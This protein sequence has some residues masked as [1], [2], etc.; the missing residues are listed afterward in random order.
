MITSETKNKYIQIIN[1]IGYEDPAVEAIVEFIRTY[2]GTED[3]AFAFLCLS[4]TGLLMQ[5]K[6]LKI[7]A[8]GYDQ[9]EESSDRICGQIESIKRDFG[10]ASQGKLPET[11]PATKIPY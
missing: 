7:K 5:V 8:D 10:R 6:A 1:N 11:P 4:V 9:M 2:N 3:N